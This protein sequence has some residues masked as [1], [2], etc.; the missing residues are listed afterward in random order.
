M[1][2]CLMTNDRSHIALVDYWYTLSSSSLLFSTLY[3]INFPV[4]PPFS[5]CQRR[6]I[7][8]FLIASTVIPSS[9]SQ[10][11]RHFSLQFCF[12]ATVSQW[13]TAGGG[14]EGGNPNSR[15]GAA[16]ETEN[17]HEDKICEYRTR[18]IT[19]GWK[20]PLRSDRCERNHR[21]SWGLCEFW[22]VW[23]F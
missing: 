12:M 8:F 18:N 20:G 3:V 9:A 11:S 14:G 13:G 23:Y 1:K 19:L 22:Q 4:F 21:D 2:D 10:D 15:G 7:S 6:F 5:N 16:S 17:I